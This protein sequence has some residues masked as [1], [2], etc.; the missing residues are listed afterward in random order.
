MADEPTKTR[1]ILEGL[2]EILKDSPLCPV[3][4]G[5]CYSWASRQFLKEDMGDAKLQ[6]GKVLDRWGNTS[7]GTGGYYDHA[8]IEREGRIYDWQTMEGPGKHGSKGKDGWSKEEFED[9]FQPKDITTYQGEE[10]LILAARHGHYGPWEKTTEPRPTEQATVPSEIQQAIS[11]TSTA[12][13]SADLA[14]RFTEAWEARR[15]EMGARAKETGPRAALRGLGWFGTL[16]T[17]GEELVEQLPSDSPL[18]DAL[19]RDPFL[20]VRQVPD[21]T[22][23]DISNLSETLLS[24]KPVD[25]GP[26]MGAEKEII[27]NIG[28]WIERQFGAGE[29]EQEPTG[30]ATLPEA[31]RMFPY[32]PEKGYGGSWLHHGGPYGFTRF[33]IGQ[34][35]TGEGAGAFHT[36]GPSGYFTEIPT[37][38]TWY[39][40]TTSPVPHPRFGDESP[41]DFQARLLK[42][43]ESFIDDNPS[44]TDTTFD[45]GYGGEWVE[46][47]E[48]GVENARRGDFK[49]RVYKLTNEL[50][51]FLERGGRWHHGQWIAPTSVEEVDK[52]LN[53]RIAELEETL[54]RGT[55][56]SL[57]RPRIQYAARAHGW[58]S[59]DELLRKELL[60][61]SRYG[62]PSKPED[63]GVP[64][65]P[66][67]RWTVEADLKIL[68]DMQEAGPL[69]HKPGYEYQ[70]KVP[71]SLYS[72]LLVWEDA[73]KDQ[74]PNDPERRK[75]AIAIAE[76]LYK[77]IHPR[78]L[79]V[80]RDTTLQQLVREI[81]MD[82]SGRI[83]P[84]E[85]ESMFRDAGIPGH[86]YLEAT[87]RLEGKTPEAQHNMVIWDQSVLDKDFQ[88]TERRGEG[89]TTQRYEEG[90]LVHGP[91]SVN[92]DVLEYGMRR[93][94]AERLM[95]PPRTLYAEGGLA[96]LPRNPVL[97]GQ[98]HMLAYITPEEA[99]TLRAQGGGVTPT[100]GQYRGPGGI[101]SF[102]VAGLAG[103]GQM[104]G[105]HGGGGQGVGH[106]Q[107]VAAAQAAAAANAAAAAA[108]ATAQSPTGRDIPTPTQLSSSKEMGDESLPELESKTM[109]KFANMPPS[110]FNS[111]FGKYAPYG[112]SLH[113]KV[114][115]QDD[116]IDMPPE[117]FSALRSNPATTVVGD[118][119]STFGKAVSAFGLAALGLAVPALS[120]PTSIMSLA[121]YAAKKPGDP[122]ISALG[123]IGDQAAKSFG[124]KDVADMTVD[125]S[126]PEVGL[127]EAVS[128]AFAPV[129]SAVQDIHGF[130]APPVHDI[131]QSLGLHS[132][133]PQFSVTPDNMGSGIEQPQAAAQPLPP[134]PIDHTGPLGTEVQDPL[135]GDIYESGLISP[136]F[137]IDELRKYG[138]GQ[139]PPTTS[140]FAHGGFV[141]KPLYSRN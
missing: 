102:Q 76:N 7:A 69:Y 85:L 123:F 84:G 138:I 93:T 33:D 41:L 77:R 117:E 46:I 62:T 103:I 92:P 43:Y 75:S 4:A 15:A 120:I 10:P 115:T 109:A 72:E 94:P 20:L 14:A 105:V 126:L 71:E 39:R 87:S 64:L 5:E 130:V 83:A 44:Y 65:E 97:G 119:N 16:L 106:G 19:E 129:Q 104:G 108:A 135:G 22:D 60:H 30:I 107:G 32:D 82:G 90:G 98:Q 73:I 134:L 124:Y 140:I 35:G 112:L 70:Y 127:S 1:N 3:S 53:P 121:R 57:T 86:Y 21:F 67:Q 78:L 122:P 91:L 128:E 34:V 89:D 8:W 66:W 9:Y 111:I 51:Q 45:T 80:A 63:P 79:H 118:P 95:R 125:V 88:L 38:G 131:A 113:G 23:I 59:P 54:D 49:D 136:A 139:I 52:W 18:R 81:K 56:Y 25:E 132:E 28:D 6:H 11:T 27:A 58:P 50:S 37:K 12:A 55:T 74:F 141:D 100:G 40:K 36:G 114:F 133:S 2:D 47:G 13:T 96:S 101:A 29:P 137:T 116:F 42:K 48:K 26:W 61:G 99:S 24:D 110:Q 31:M 68:R 17:V